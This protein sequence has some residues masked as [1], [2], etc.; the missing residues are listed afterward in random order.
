[1]TQ[2]NLKLKVARADGLPGFAAYLQGTVLEQGSTTIGLEPNQA[3][4][5]L[6]I[7]AV[8]DDN[9]VIQEDGSP[10]PPRTAEER[11]RELV[12]HLM[13]EFGHALEE[14]LGLEFDE[15]DMDRIVAR[16]QPGADR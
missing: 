5:L 12:E 3:L 2:Q 11:K 4:V 9:A 1:M 16:Y 7:E 10:I 6:D 13:H 8:F 14:F 15:D